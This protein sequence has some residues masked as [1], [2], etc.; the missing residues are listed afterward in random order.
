MNKKNSKGTGHCAVG[1]ASGDV[2]ASAILHRQHPALDRI[3]RHRVVAG[4]PGSHTAT[5]GS[6]NKA[7]EFS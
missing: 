1:L 7:D 6:A 4:V 5:A 3:V 2:D